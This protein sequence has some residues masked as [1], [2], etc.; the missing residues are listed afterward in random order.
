VAIAGRGG[1]LKTG[2]NGK[3]GGWRAMKKCKKEKFK[4]FVLLVWKGGR[5]SKVEK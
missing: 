3:G 1:P 4:K 5:W 2:D